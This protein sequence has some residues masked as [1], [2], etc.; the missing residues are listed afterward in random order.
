MTFDKKTNK[1]KWKINQSKSL[2]HYYFLSCNKTRCHIDVKND[3]NDLAQVYFFHSAYSLPTDYGSVSH[4]PILN[5]FTRV[6]SYIRY[7]AS[8]IV[9]ILT[10]FHVVTL[11]TCFWISTY[12]YFNQLIADA[13]V[14][15]R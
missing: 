14:F 9:R 10:L 15:V 6:I 1:P 7:A 5:R 12:M 11:R 2:L 8:N 4:P 3:C 13:S